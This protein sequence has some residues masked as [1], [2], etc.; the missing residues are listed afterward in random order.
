MVIDLQN[1]TKLY[2]LAFQPER[3]HWRRAA[4]VGALTP[5]FAGVWAADALART[6][7][8]KLH[9]EILEQDIGQP[10]F[11]MASP[12]SG[13]TLLH[14]LM[15][16]DD[17]FT[18][19]RLW[20]TMFP[21]MSL[22]TLVDMMTKADELVGSPFDKVQ[23]AFARWA[24]GGWEGIH[25]TRFDEAEEDEASFV[26]AGSTPSLWMVVP[27]VRDT[28]EFGDL[29]TSPIRDRFVAYFRGT[30]QRHLH[31]AQRNG[32]RKT[33][34][35]K[36]VL[37]A[38]RLGVVQEAAPEARFVNIVRHPYRTM[39][40]FMSFFTTPWRFHS[41]DVPIDGPEAR[42]FA[43]LMMD[44]ALS[45]HRFMQTLPDDRG[46]TIYYADLIRDPETEIMKIYD[47]FGLE[48]SER[49]RARLH[50]VLSE[51]RHYASGHA[52]TLE[53]YGL[54]EDLVY[55]RLREIFDAHGLARHPSEA[56]GI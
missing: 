6:L 55:E 50:D 30:L 42:A 56:E 5:V 26:L 13:T 10:I 21:A 38:H 39:A 31:H 9:P 8:E 1:I 54:T 40:S 16:L 33:L 43:E 20:Q 27:F 32:E 11:I 34:L 45:I 17:Q 41:P 18:S 25:K 15:S 47:R 48:A 52:Y 22:Y 53:Q 3:F 4:F 37:L 7:D 14:R 2:K 28:P 12:R 29:D 46:I 36:N 49:F 44:Y 19:F 24:F 51:E 23:K 35:A